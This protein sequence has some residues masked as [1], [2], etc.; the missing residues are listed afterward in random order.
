M[1]TDALGALVLRIH[2]QLIITG[3]Q[4]EKQ[5]ECYLIKKLNFATEKEWHPQVQNVAKLWLAVAVR[6]KHH[7]SGSSFSHTC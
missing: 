6:A 3:S 1:F 7:R 2:W 4:V 5:F